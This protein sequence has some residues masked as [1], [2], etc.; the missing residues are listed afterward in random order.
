[1]LCFLRSDTLSFIFSF[2]NCIILHPPVPIFFKGISLPLV[3]PAL[4][5]FMGLYFRLRHRH[6]AFHASQAY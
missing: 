3:L 5:I 2:G 1:M 6:S 4:D